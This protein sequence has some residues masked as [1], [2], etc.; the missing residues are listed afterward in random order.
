VRRSSAVTRVR[1][2]IC[3][4]KHSTFTRIK[5][6]TLYIDKDIFTPMKGLYAYRYFAFVVDNISKIARVGRGK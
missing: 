6:L 3:A 4:Y 1:T 2:L 5:I